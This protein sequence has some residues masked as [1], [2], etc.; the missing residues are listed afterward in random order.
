MFDLPPG[1]V[2]HLARELADL[3]GS[4]PTEAVEIALREAIARH[5]VRIAAK[6]EKL[7]RI[8]A[9]CAAL[10]VRDVRTPEES[11]G[12]DDIGLPD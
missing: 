11:V 2:R 4:T 9:D 8:A 5:R 10:P 6:R 12:Y 3:T 7:G 1:N